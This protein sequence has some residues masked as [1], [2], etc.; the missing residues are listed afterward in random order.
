MGSKSG[1]ACGKDD[2]VAIGHGEGEGAGGGCAPSHAERKRG[3]GK[4]NSKGPCSGIKCQ[5]VEHV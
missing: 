1:P 2:R 5:S 4:I 3:G